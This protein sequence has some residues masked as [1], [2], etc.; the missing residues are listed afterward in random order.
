MVDAAAIPSA[1][2]RGCRCIFIIVVLS[3][4]DDASG[5]E[6]FSRPVQNDAGLDTGNHDSSAMMEWLGALQRWRDEEGSGALHVLSV[7][8][9]RHRPPGRQEDSGDSMLEQS[10]DALMSLFK[11]ACAEQETRQNKEKEAPSSGENASIRTILHDDLIQLLRSALEDEDVLGFTPLHL[12]ALVNATHVRQ[13]DLCVTVHGRVVDNDHANDGISLGLLENIARAVHAEPSPVSRTWHCT[14][15]E[16]LQLFDDRTDENIDASQHGA[17][18]VADTG[19]EQTWPRVM[20]YN[21]ENG[22]EEH[23]D[24]RKLASMSHMKTYCPFYRGSEDY[25]RYMLTQILGEESALSQK[26][27]LMYAKVENLPEGLTNSNIDNDYDISMPQNLPNV[28]FFFV[29]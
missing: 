20:V 9:T 25:L 19:S 4:S 28:S 22:S 16:L 10:Q 21:R 18:K 3:S 26:H 12:A 29:G 1:T 24:V 27:R 5:D 6:S 14:P 13:S 15:R 7:Y 2:I 11:R 23:L 8:P 17:V